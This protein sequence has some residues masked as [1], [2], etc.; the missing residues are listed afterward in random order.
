MEYTKTILITQRRSMFIMSCLTEKILEEDETV[1]EE[2]TFDDGL[3]MEVKCC[4][5]QEEP[6]WTEAVLFAK[7]DKGA[8]VEVACSDASDEFLGEWELEYNGNKYI[9]NVVEQ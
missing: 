5:S 3:V 4:G 2:A 8:Y 1:R 9:V 7:S 6:A